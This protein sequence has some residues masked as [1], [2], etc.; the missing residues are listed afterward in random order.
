MSH[1]LWFQDS[2]P[3]SYTHLVD[4]FDRYYRTQAD[5]YLETRE[6]EE[7][8]VKQIIDAAVS[9]THLDV[10]KRQN[11]EAVMALRFQ[12]NH[13]VW[14]YQFITGWQK[15][16]KLHLMIWLET[17]SYTHLDVYKRQM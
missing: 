17:V 9:Y 5:P 2:V 7:L 11:S 6:R 4:Y 12:E 8:F 13:F 3:V 1:S 10:Y 15:K 16:K 14:R